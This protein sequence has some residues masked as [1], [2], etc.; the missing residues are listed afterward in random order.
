[1]NRFEKYYPYQGEE[2]RQVMAALAEHR[3]A[4]SLFP[5][6]SQ[7]DLR[8]RF[9]AY[10]DVRDFQAD[11]MY[12]GCRYV[13]EH[14]MSQFTWSGAEHLDGSPSLFISNHRDI[15]LDTML[16]QYLLISIGRDTT[17][18]VV[19]TNLF[20]MPLMAQMAR[21]NKMFGIDRGGNRMEYYQSLI[22]MSAYLRHLVTERRESAWIA[23]RNGRTKDGIDRTDPA[24]LKMIAA[25]GNPS[26]PVGA[27]HAMHIVPLC[28]SYEWEPCGRQKARE[29]CLRRQGPYVKAPG[30]DTQSIVNGIM[31]FKGRVH[32]SVCPPL[33]LDELATTDGD[34]HQVAAL[35]DRSIAQGRTTFDNNRIAKAMLDGT[36][37]P[38]SKATA[39]FQRYIDNACAQY[40]DCDNYRTTLLQ[41]YANSVL[42][43]L[44]R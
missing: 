6:L 23:Q 3:I 11:A 8:C 26:D 41:I 13:V 22:E 24:L 29:V 4:Q 44:I 42:N 37:L 20:E 36:P 15:V 16:L 1:M 18:V 30:E 2:F 27:L 19:G 14:T 25:T 35:I 17:H 9:A 38:D 33:T 12:R 28:V 31:D 5:E 34:F 39:D 7:D 21:V 40:P 32:L 10:R 43:S